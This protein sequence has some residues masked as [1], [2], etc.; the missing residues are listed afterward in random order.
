MSIG[1]IS[2]AAAGASGTG[3]TE[4]RAGSD[5]YSDGV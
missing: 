4:G 3:K 2:S 5:D 1:R